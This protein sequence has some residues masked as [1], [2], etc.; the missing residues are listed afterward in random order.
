MSRHSNPFPSSEFFHPFIESSNSEGVFQ[1]C[2]DVHITRSFI[3]SFTDTVIANWLI[4]AFSVFMTI[5]FVICTLINIFTTCW[6][7]KVPRSHR[8]TISSI[9]SVTNTVI[10]LIR[11]QRIAPNHLVLALTGSG[12]WIPVLD[13]NLVQNLAYQHSTHYQNKCAF[14]EHTH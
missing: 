2:T 6:I 1:N 4:I 5:I 13:Q 3:S 9:A 12:A 7:W 14:P 10:S 11:D 8:L